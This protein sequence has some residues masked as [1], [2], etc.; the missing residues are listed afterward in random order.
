MGTVAVMIP[1]YVQPHLPLAE[2]QVVI[3]ARS[4]EE[5]VHPPCLKNSESWRGAPTTPGEVKGYVSSGQEQSPMRIL[6]N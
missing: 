4:F 1:H 3:V 5:T 6:F 2:Q